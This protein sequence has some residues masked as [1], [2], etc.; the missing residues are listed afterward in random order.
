MFEDQTFEEI[1]DRMLSRISA[2]IDTREGS[3]I[4]NALAPAAAELAKS[5]IWLDTVLELV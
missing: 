3:V 4:Y 2:D 5:Y 1:M